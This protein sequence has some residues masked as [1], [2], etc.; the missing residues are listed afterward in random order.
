MG[1]IWLDEASSGVRVDLIVLP[2]MYGNLRVVVYRLFPPSSLS[3][4]I[5]C[6]EEDL[7]VNKSGIIT[8]FI[9]NPFKNTQSS[10]EAATLV[11][12]RVTV[13]SLGS[14]KCCSPQTPLSR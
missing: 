13:A 10:P 2:G 12:Q 8:V 1:D 11:M 5:F 3:G 6:S 14:K 4:Y 9:P 7:F